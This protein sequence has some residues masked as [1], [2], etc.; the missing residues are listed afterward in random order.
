MCCFSCVYSCAGAA[1]LGRNVLTKQWRQ[2]TARGVRRVV[3]RTPTARAAVLFACLPRLS[4]AAMRHAAAPGSGVPGL[5]WLRR[6]WVPRTHA[7]TRVGANPTAA[8]QAALCV[9][10]RA[11]RMTGCVTRNAGVEEEERQGSAL[12]LTP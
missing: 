5:S 10:T 2:R 3:V 7:R 4:S 11:T 12:Q 1:F 9:S 6:R 8:A